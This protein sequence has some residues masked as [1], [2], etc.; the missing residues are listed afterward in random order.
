[1]LIKYPDSHA[2]TLLLLCRD[3]VKGDNKLYV[4]STSQLSVG[5]GVR[6]TLDNPTNNALI[7]DLHS[8]AIPSN[9]NLGA[10]ANLVSFM[11]KVVEVRAVSIYKVWPLQLTPE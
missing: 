8:G 3:A 2:C 6:M 1:L 5:D 10:R 7:A 9:A 4:E 11:A